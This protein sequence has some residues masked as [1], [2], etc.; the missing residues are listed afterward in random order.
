[1]R[2]YLKLCTEFYDFDKPSAPADALAFYLRYATEGSGGAIL[3]PMCGT[4]RFLVPLRERG[5]DIDG[6]DASPHML[7]A[8][9]SKLER[10]G[11]TTAGVEQQF[12]HEL[13]VQRQYALVFIPSG[14]FQ[15]ITDPALV[16][17]SLRRI[18]NALRPGGTFVFEC[19]IHKPAESS[20][21]PWG[22]RWITRPADGAR[23][24]ISWLGRYDSATSVNYNLHRYE[25][26]QDGKLLT[27]E[28]EEFDLRQY[29]ARE[30]KTLLENA[31][32]ADIRMCKT[33][34]RSQP[35]DESSNDDAVIECRKP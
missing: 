20:S 24:L 21:W 31:G 4:G 10:L 7:Q 13:A 28:L 33:Y 5:F 18:H 8:C 15:L 19:G 35:A 3:E 17:E 16:E 11:L 26:F 27:T 34:D 29:S 6:S 14:S 32:F 22:G 12:L 23:I 25:L 30:L 1:M 2:S 9:R